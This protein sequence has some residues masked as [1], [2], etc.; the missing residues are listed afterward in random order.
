MLIYQLLIRL[1]SPLALFLIISDAIKKHG[2]WIFFLQRLGFGY[3]KPEH[4]S[5][6]IWIHC[7]SVGEVKAAEPLIRSL[8]PEAEILLTT[9][10]PT[11]YALIQTLFKQNVSY[12]YCPLD[13]PYAIRRF[14][15][16]YAPEKLWV[17][18]TEI[19]PNLYRLA[20]KN[21]IEISILNARL[22]KK[23]LN[24]PEWL[25]QSYEKTLS[26]VT[27]LLVRNDQEAKHFQQLHAPE[28]AIRVV[29]NLKF[30]AIAKTVKTECPVDRPYVLLA[31]SHD[32]EEAEITQRWLALQ[33]PEL[34]VIV[35]RHP[36]RAI[37]I[38]N[39]LPLNRN[40]ISVHSLGENIHA[41]TL[42]YID[43]R[44]G[45]LTPFYCH[46]KLV[47]M[48]G[49]FVPKGGHNV[50][51]PAA[52]GVPIL[53]G[54]DMSD[55]EAESE[56]LRKHN[57]LLQCPDYDALF[58]EINR[59]IDADNER[60]KMGD[61]AKQALQDQTHVLEDYLQILAPKLSLHPAKE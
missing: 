14:L 60:K 30:A 55:F 19:W 34:L 10:T 31:S 7:A 40:Q 20:H 36:K 46:A 11:G 2:G 32:N 53:T 49:A 37:Q 28:K 48:G 58:S 6:S 38:V 29:G 43:D 1:L 12:A 18:E 4:R 52:C 51:E 15:R 56:L 21:G 33:R 3:K 44:I 54:P 27:H 47:V 25:K 17:I 59:I 9:N 24:S 22:S 39:S 61:A 8:Q 5:S 45:A 57:A 13:Y 26:L 42:V 23:T 41:T 35:P 16:T 50:L